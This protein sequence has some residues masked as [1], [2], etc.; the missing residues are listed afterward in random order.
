MG[1]SAYIDQPLS[2]F[3]ANQKQVS[4]SLPVAPPQ[5][6]PAAPSPTAKPNQG[7]PA[8][9][10]R[11]QSLLTE[12]HAATA[13]LTSARQALEDARYLARNGMANNLTFATH[14][15]HVA[16][17]NWLRTGEAFVNAR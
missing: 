10:A 15:E 6:K 11:Q 4:A 5:P 2:K 8:M 13:R 17:H 14:V 16:Y 3:I 7:I 12:L 9:T 1:L